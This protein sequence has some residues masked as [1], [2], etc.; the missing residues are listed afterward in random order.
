MSEDVPQIAV[1]LPRRLLTRIDARAEAH[2]L[3]R[4]AWIVKAL[5]RAVE[6]P[7]QVTTKQERF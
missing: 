5:Q 7:S 2:N 1:R 6:L 4:N 3:S